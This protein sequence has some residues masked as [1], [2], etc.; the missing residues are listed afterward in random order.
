MAPG[1]RSQDVNRD[2]DDSRS[3]FEEEG[4]QNDDDRANT[5][6]IDNPTSN[7]NTLAQATLIALIRTLTRSN[8]PPSSK[9]TDVRSPDKFNGLDRSKLRTYFAQC[10]LVFRANPRK[11]DTDTKKV[12]YACS[13]LDGLAFDWYENIVDQ[14]DEPAWFHDW[15]LFRTTLDYHFGEI[16]PSHA[17]ERKIRNLHMTERDT[18]INYITKFRTYL[19]KLDWNDKAIT[20]EFRRGLNGRIKDNLAKVDYEDLDFANLEQLVI[21]IDARHQERR[22]ERDHERHGNADEV[23]PRPHR[24]DGRPSTRR[25][26]PT[27]T[28]IGYLKPTV[29]T[30]SQ[31]TVSTSKQPP[32]KTNLP[33]DSKGKVTEEEKARRARLGLCS[34]CGGKHTID[35]CTV[36]PKTN[37]RAATTTF[38]VQGFQ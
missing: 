21:K 20:A 4:S 26:S 35:D 8:E 14:P 5:P 37:L 17:A 23:R 19:G 2:D 9:G 22:M 1:L 11:F 15:T 3:N 33:L 12:T 6:T 24:E 31:T 34:Y 27:T 18:V 36:K 32:S 38:S 7:I 25:S 10:L 29:T 16:N 30:T 28:N 13:Y